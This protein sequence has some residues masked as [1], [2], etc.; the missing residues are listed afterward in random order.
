MKIIHTPGRIYTTGGVEEYVHHLTGELIRRGHEV[1][2]VSSDVTNT[3]V[4][5]QDA[6]VRL[7]RHIG[8]LGNTPITPGFPLDI[9]NRDFDIIHTHLPTPWSADWS[10]VVAGL[11]KKPLILTYHS[12]ITGTGI[13]RLIAEIYNRTALFAL[14][15]A[16]DRI[17]LTRSQ[18][19]PESLHRFREK[20][21]IIP[22]GVDNQEFFPSE[23]ELTCDIF[24]L[25]VLDE[26]HDYKG[27]DIFFSAIQRVKEKIP[28]LR[29]LFGG[30]GSRLATYMTMAKSMGL[31]STIHFTGYIPQQQLREYYNGCAVFVLPSQS[32][33]LETF[34]IVLLEAMACGRPVITTV[35]AGMAEDIIRHETGIVIRMGD[36]EA[37]AEAI[38]TVLR[39]DALGKRMGLAGRRLIENTYDWKIIGGQIEQLYKDVL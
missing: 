32:P 7:L 8:T 26:F 27:I 25:S 23:G 28:S 30:G 13:T 16:A 21:E 10:A 36:P 6:T 3:E 15:S 1:T 20:I 35:A 29:V 2:I 38:L 17:I 19:L 4:F 37:L 9:W 12:A 22:I 39:N 11:K 14:F 34:G 33:E 18:F 31:G 24:F 5:E